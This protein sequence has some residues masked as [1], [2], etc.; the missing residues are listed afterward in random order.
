M[1]SIIETVYPALKTVIQ[2]ALGSEYVELTHVIHVEMNKFNDSTRRWGLAPGGVPE[3]QGNTKA[4]TMD[5]QFA[6]VLTDEYITDQFGDSGVIT[7]VLSLMGKFEDLWKQ[8]SLQKGNVYAQAHLIGGFDVQDPVILD[9]E[10]I[11]AIQGK[12]F[13][14]V[15]NSF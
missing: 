1:T 9:E 3:Q 13:V 11:I 2:S 8:L 12:F 7:K 6:I 15:Q 4:N 10:K 14:R 5:L